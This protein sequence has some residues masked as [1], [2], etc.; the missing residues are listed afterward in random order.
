M[1]RN[2]MMKMAKK[3][4]KESK[5]IN[6]LKEMYYSKSEKI[7]FNNFFVKNIKMLWIDF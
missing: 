5:Y 3:R 4:E 2:E 6:R 7:I 1:Q